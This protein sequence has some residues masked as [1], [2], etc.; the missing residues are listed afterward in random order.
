VPFSHHI[1]KRSRQPK[2]RIALDAG[3]QLGEGPHWDAGAGELLRVDI[4]RGLVHGWRPDTGA[5]WSLQLDGEVSAVVPRSGGGLVLA[6]E[7]DLVLF[8]DGTRRRLATT[9]QDVADNRFNDCRADPQ[10]RL[11]AGTMSR[12]RTSGA[13]GLYRLA[14]GGALERVLGDTT[15]SNGLG[16][17]PAG[18]RLYFIDSPTRRIDVFDFDGASGAVAHR[19]P[20]ATIDPGR[21]LPDG[22]AVDAE[23]GVWVCLFGGAAIHRYSPDGALDAVVA[24]PVT[25]PTC[26]AFGG[27][28]LTTLYVTSAQHRLS[29]EQLAAEPHAGAVL[30]I[31]VE[32]AGLPSHRFAG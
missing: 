27:A 1:L 23:G 4:I 16:W 6:I 32:I 13:A 21:G 14:P 17:S 26:P 24:L 9:E 19:R 29:R 3:D 18:D 30:A 22:L 7:H 10:G 5:S 31:D 12:S 11:W 2:A 8:S 20:F 15:I 25:N 28:D